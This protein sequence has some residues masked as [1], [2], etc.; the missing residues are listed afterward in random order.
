[1]AHSLVADGHIATAILWDLVAHLPSVSIERRTAENYVPSPATQS[2]QLAISSGG[3]LYALS[4]T[5]SDMLLA[6][7]SEAD[8]GISRTSLGT[9]EQIE[10]D[11][12]LCDEIWVLRKS[13][14]D[15][16]KNELVKP[17]YIDGEAKRVDF[18]AGHFKSKLDLALK[19]IGVSVV[20]TIIGVATPLGFQTFTDKILP[21]A[22]QNS[23]IAI[24]TLLV[25]GAAAANV[26]SCYQNYLQSVL[27]A[28]YQ[29]GLG[30][31]VFARLMAMD[32]PYLDK[33]KVGDLTKLVDQ[34]EESSNFLVMQLLGTITAVISLFVVLPLLFLYDVQLASI[35][36]GIGLLM[37]TTIALSLGALR[38]RVKQAYGYDASF[39]S[40]LIEALK[41]MHTIK[42]LSNEP[43]F[44]HKTNHALEVNLY[45]FFNV[46]RLRHILGSI[47][48]F[49]SQLISI[50]VIFFGA[51]AVFAN[52]MTIGQ[53]I[54]FNMLA[55][56]V[57]G[58]LVAVVMTAAGWENFRLARSKLLEL[59]PPDESQLLDGDHINLSGDIVFEDVW[60]RYPATEEWVLKGI[61]LTI[62]QGDIVGVVGSS[63]SGKS[64]LA[65][66][67]MGFYPPTK[68]KILINGYDVT[69]IA[70]RK[71]RSRIA[72]VQQTS[73]LFNNSVLENI[74]LGRMGSDYEDILEAAKASGAE[75]FIEEMP[76]RYMTE[77]AE[78]GSNLSGGQ[79]QR[80]A[81]A[82]ALVRDA[83]IMLFDEATSA[84]DNETEEHIK[85]TIYKSCQGRTGVIIAHRLN[86]LSY[87][88]RLIVIRNGEV[89]A[90]GAHAELLKTENSYKRMWESMLKRDTLIM[91]QAL[92]G[93]AAN[94]V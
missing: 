23:L 52:Q 90:D 64:T 43:Y 94:A 47:L 66:L 14:Q 38:K 2:L 53:L 89:E 85:G 77:L 1:M 48:G 58:P 19:I 51:Q 31:E 76:N 10:E 17:V 93:E 34:V 11:L 50:A 15:Q 21:Y 16:T 67:I 44:R 13:D 42:A 92:E 20:V 22:A 71:L 84:L 61:N 86:T 55:N 27:F 9:W 35:V 28:K 54:A 91:G 49:Q 74:H 75:E 65:A 59:V 73:F 72:S 32:I 4:A 18:V 36:L 12:D 62:K 29:N 45:G 68:G 39:Q 30:K 57:V 24:I 8:G 88:Q 70:P 7:R 79:R 63:G 80:L 41:G 5:S 60:F 81:I 3:D 46:S 82:R 33:H 40:V 78:D 26:L 6:I 37:A 87:C 56:N 69:T 25:L 83:D